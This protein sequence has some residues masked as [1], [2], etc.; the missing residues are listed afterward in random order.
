MKI[1]VY[2]IALNEKQFVK[3]WYESAK[4][5]DF[6]LLADTGSTDGTAELARELG[7][8]VVDVRI[9]PWR[10]DDARNASLA[11][12]PLDIDYCIALDVDEILV[13]GWR[14][15]IEKTP[16]HVTRPRYKYV[17]SWNGDGSEGLVYGG[18]KIHARQGYRWKHPVH[19][20][21]NSYL[22]P[23][24]QEWIGLQIHHHPDHTKSRG[25]YFPMLEMAVA[26]DPEDDRN[27]HYLGRE[28]FFHNMCDKAKA[29]LQRHLS[30]QRAQWKPER[31]ASMRYIAKCSEDQEREEWF[32]KA[33]LEYP[34][35]RE[36]WVDLA[37]YYYERSMW[38]DCYKTVLR[39]LEIKEKPL[40]YL[41][42]PKAWGSF[43]YDIAA[44]AAYN[45]GYKEEALTFGQEA[46]NLNPT[47]ERLK[48]N[49]EFYKES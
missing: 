19:E 45:L 9:K 46:L 37:E 2:S 24:V 4:E 30:L 23:E 5:A 42:D 21:L 10:F 29:E 28:Y 17:W 39:A 41:N 15:Q 25:Q 16:S 33:A 22:I 44:I 6:I 20:V 43:P 18:D 36:P 34:E 35:G 38:S 47:D 31:A 14:E 1:A 8:H 27:S 12:I 49:L 3:R 32:K 11:H 40:Q 7:I 13:P 48:K 26:E